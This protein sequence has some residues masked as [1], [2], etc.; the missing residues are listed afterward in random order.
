MKRQ[1]LSVVSNSQKV[2]EKK[3]MS[4]RIRKAPKRFIEDGDENTK[5]N[6]SSNKVG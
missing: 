2:P 6:L 3:T 5:E 4:K 1:P